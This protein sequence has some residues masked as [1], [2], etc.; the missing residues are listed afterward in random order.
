MIATKMQQKK[1]IAGE[2]K[3]S[4]KDPTVKK[5]AK[6][7]SFKSGRGREM[8]VVG[9]GA[10]AGGLHS[11]ERFFKSMP[12]DSGI[13]FVL[14]SHLDPAHSSMIPELLQKVTDM[15][16]TQARENMKVE[17]N[18]IYV[19]PPNKNL[20]IMKDV[21]YL[22]TQSISPGPR[23]PINHF[24]KSLAEDKGEKAV[25]IV[26]SGMGSDGSA[27]I[28][29]IKA[30]LGMVMVEEPSDAEYSAMPENAIRTGMAD[31]VLPP[32]AMPEYLLRYVRKAKT[33]FS[34]TKVVKGEEAPQILNKVFLLLRSVTGHD[35]SSYKLTT[36]L[37]RIELLIGVTS[38][39]R[40]PGA[41]ESLADEILP[42]YL[43]EKPDDYAMRL[44]VPG[45]SS[46]E[47]AYSLAILLRELMEKEGRFF[48]T[49]I[50]ATDIDGDAI[51]TARKGFFPANIAPEVGAERLKRF[52]SKENEGYRVDKGIREMLVFAE[53]DVLRDPPFTRL[54]L[55]SCRNLLIYMNVELQKKLFPLFHYALKEKGILF[56]GPSETIGSFM[57]LYA[58]AS[59]KWKIYTR[60]PGS[61][62]APQ[63]DF[64]I[65][66]PHMERRFFGIRPFRKPALPQ[67]V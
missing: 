42:E 11:Y 65:P 41:F 45:C 33:G 58:S 46:G 20:D 31:F 64:P 59:K 52:F 47:E 19:I 12:A 66:D 30:V 67:E 62:L 7:G 34:V 55:I 49:Q 38:F 51:G 57:H 54:D 3:V 6:R 16:V 44:W 60:R 37:R 24:F 27:G 25:G 5:K 63:I 61:R 28:K 26:L 32:E 36:I 50:F 4:K 56:L 35:F 18:R 2:T 39:F 15:K 40:D 14:V 48:T 29:A 17:P 53:Q 1:K 13:A 22:E 43:K 10:S 21:L 23:S 9:I 8:F